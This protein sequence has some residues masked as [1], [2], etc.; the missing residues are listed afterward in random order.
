M[1]IAIKTY[2]AME[3]PG[4]EILVEP[5]AHVTFKRWPVQWVNVAIDH[6]RFLLALLTADGRDVVQAIWSASPFVSYIHHGRLVCEIAYTAL[7]IDFERGASRE[8]LL[9]AFA[10]TKDYFVMDSP[11]YAR[12]LRQTAQVQIIDKEV[13]K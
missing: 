2:D 7:R 8:E 11:G 12:L 9:H 13:N 1:Q 3:I 10:H 4:V 6:S 5:D